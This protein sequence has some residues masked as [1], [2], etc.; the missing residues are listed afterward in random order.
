MD[1]A[2]ADDK[3][4][5]RRGTGSRLVRRDA[6]PELLEV[7]LL[8]ITDL[9]IKCRIEVIASA[10]SALDKDVEDALRL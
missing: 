7:E 4:D 6:T 3:K 2:A 1:N 9:S 10:A 8:V 5:P